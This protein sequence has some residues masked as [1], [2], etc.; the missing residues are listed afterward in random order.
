MS[1]IRSEMTKAERTLAK[2][3][4]LYARSQDTRNVEE[5]MMAA[6]Q[7]RFL[8]DENCISEEQLK[9]SEFMDSIA[10]SQRSIPKW[11]LYM[12]LGIAKANDCVCTGVREYQIGSTFRYKGYKQDVLMCS[13][14]QDYLI[15]A[16]DRSWEEF[17]KTAD[18]KGKSASTSFK[19]GFAISIQHRLIELANEREDKFESLRISANVSTGSNLMVVKQKLVAEEFGKQKIGKTKSRVSDGGAAHAGGEAGN[20]VS[21]HKQVKKDMPIALGQF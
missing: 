10:I 7:C 1:T 16:M 3:K 9:E 20:N 5:A 4:K 2:I 15:G 8:M 19:N 11:F 14:M 13:L 17:K 21:L 6:R 12:S 18:N